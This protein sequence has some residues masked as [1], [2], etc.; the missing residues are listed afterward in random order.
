MP[1]KDLGKPPFPPLLIVDTSEPLTTDAISGLLTRRLNGASI[2]VRQA[3]G[4]PKRGGYFFHL[5]PRN[6]AVEECEVYNF[7]GTLVATL[8]VDQVVKFMNHCSG[9]QFDDWAFSFSNSVVNFKLD[10][11]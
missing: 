9:L 4:D 5:V 3:E 1:K 11:E 10:P 2:C 6:A 8:S 7:E